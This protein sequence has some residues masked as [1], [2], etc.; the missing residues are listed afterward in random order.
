M[1]IYLNLLKKIPLFEGVPETQIEGVLNCFNA[2]IKKYKPNEVIWEMD[3]KISTVGIVLKGKIYISKDDY[4][5][6]RNIITEFSQ[7]DLFGEVFL[8]AGI[9][10]S[11]VTVFSETDSDILFIKYNNIVETCPS[12]CNYHITLVKNMLKLLSKRTLLLNEKIEILGKRSIREKIICYLNAQMNK[13][14]KEEVIINFSR[15]EFA[16]FLCVDRSS[17]SRE[18]SKMQKDDLIEING[19]KI[20]VIDTL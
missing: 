11:P 7:G 9:E 20:K 12:A 17:L 13:T 5:G 16:D 14:R 3:D 19:K 1:K 2:T 10:R 18:L 4:L 6:V 8:S 15:Q